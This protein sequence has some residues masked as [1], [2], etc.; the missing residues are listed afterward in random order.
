MGGPDPNPA[1]SLD[2]RRF[3]SLVAGGM[4]GIAGC[5]GGDDTPTPTDAD[6]PTSTPTSTATPTA[7]TGGSGGASP[8]HTADPSPTHTPTATDSPTPT[9]PDTETPTDTPT[10]TASRTNAAD[11]RVVVGPAG[12][13]TFDPSEFAIAAGDTVVWT[14]DSGGHNVRPAS[15][16]AASGWG[17]TPGGDGTTYDEGYTHR[18]TFDAPGEYEYYCAPH[19]S[20]GMTG[21]FTVE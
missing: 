10:P 4:A 12:T 6:S 13:F 20:L 18:Y 16:P 19:R 9:E 5:T 21:T 7:A 17:G 11:Q 2:R 3:V 14:W 8:T 1:M 15:T